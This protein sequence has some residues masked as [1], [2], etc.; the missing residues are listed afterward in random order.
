MEGLGFTVESQVPS[1][2]P[3]TGRYTYRATH[4]WEFPKI[5]GTLLG[6]LIIRIIIFWGL[7]W[8]PLI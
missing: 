8:G 2:R 5:R 4:V 3:Y 1:T 7:H 6:V